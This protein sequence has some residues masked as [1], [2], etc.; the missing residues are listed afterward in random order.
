MIVPTIN[1]A[2][3]FCDELLIEIRDV[4]WSMTVCFT[5]CVRDG[6]SKQFKSQMKDSIEATPLIVM[7]YSAVAKHLGSMIGYIY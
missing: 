3:Q 1:I 5:P 2:E 4:N 6:A 7:T